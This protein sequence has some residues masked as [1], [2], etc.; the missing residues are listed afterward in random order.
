MIKRIALVLLGLLI[1]AGLAVAGAYVFRQDLVAWALRD[2]LETRG[3]AVQSLEVSEVS[4]R[5]LVLE[6]VTLGTGAEVSAGR[7][8]VS[9][10]AL[11]LMEGEVSE[12]Q[13]NDAVI[14]LDL[15]GEAAPLGSL[16]GLMSQGSSGSGEETPPLPEINFAD[17]KI[18]AKT[19]HGEILVDLDGSF[20]AEDN[21]DLATALAFEATSGPDRLAGSLAITLEADQ[22]VSGEIVADD[23]AL[24]LPD[25][26]IGSLSGQIGFIVVEGWP[27]I[28]TG[29]L[30]LAD[31]ALPGSGLE[32]AALKTARAEIEIDETRAAIKADLLASDGGL[33]LRFVGDAQNYMT[34]PRVK[35]DLTAEGRA[36]SYAWALLALPKPAAGEARLALSGNGHTA[37]FTDLRTKDPLEWLG[38]AALES[39]IDL[40]VDGLTYAEGITG[41]SA[42]L[43]AAVAV[44]QSALRVN[45]LEE[46]KITAQSVSP[47]LAARFG[48]PPE[49]AGQFSEDLSLTLNSEEAS[50]ALLEADLGKKVIDWFYATRAKAGSAGAEATFAGKGV[51][52]TTAAGELTDLSADPVRLSL[53]NLTY[54]GYKLSAAELAGKFSGLPDALAGSLEASVQLSDFRAGPLRAGQVSF[55]GPLDLTRSGKDTTVTLAGPSTLR[56]KKVAPLDAVRIRESLRFDLSKG[57]I[58]ATQEGPDQVSM[59]SKLSVQPRPFTLWMDRED[60]GP[61]EIQLNPGSMR[62]ESAIDAQGKFTGRTTLRR[63]GLTLPEPEMKLSQVSATVNLTPFRKGVIADFDVGSVQ[64]LAAAPL[65]TPVGIEGRLRRDRDLFQVNGK[66]KGPPGSEAIRFTGEHSIKSGF[67]NLQ[68]D[69]DPLSFS[70]GGLQPGGLM[71]DMAALKNVSGTVTAGGL[72][73]WNKEG[74]SSNGLVNLSGMGVEVAGARLR[75]LNLNLRLSDLLPPQSPPGQSLTIDGIETAVPVQNVALHFEMR[76]GPVPSFAI[77]SGRLAFIGGTISLTPLTLDPLAQRHDLELIVEG[78]DLE[79]LFDLV[80]VDGLTGNGKL[81]GRL[82][83]TIQ[84]SRVALTEGK[85]A[86]LAPGILQFRS[87][88]AASLLASGGDQVQLLLQALENFHYENLSLKMDKSADDELLATL[89]ILGQNPEVLDGQPFQLNINLESNIGKVL[90]ALAKGYQLSN[91]ALMRAFRLK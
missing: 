46:A 36:D 4:D 62:I 81:A 2:Q 74:I 85:L 45:L 38:A 84:G 70:P 89:S 91:E 64:H 75:G 55:N 57:V 50:P 73:N 44:S 34:D 21:G 7:A 26:T 83:I 9:F 66:A 12:V 58:T 71:P 61:L 53:K 77:E 80:Q 28:I 18:L 88:A 47:D 23:G 69:L 20:W 87:E 56:L 86:A 8:E 19:T 90:E 27:Q 30:A 78:L 65:F 40:K 52:Q 37:V 24:A 43:R 76:P 14:K 6:D 39:N 1:L 63:A 51:L 11:R 17:S 10:D 60:S 3:V 49:I 22:T 35:L 33:S 68:I 72:I 31:V 32:G 54:S 42:T 16:Q 48:L 79:K 13:L 25:A 82:P 29:D 5:L 41:L 67:G 15:T 59:Q